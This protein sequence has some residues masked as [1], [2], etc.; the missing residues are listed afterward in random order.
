[1]I[2]SKQYQTLAS[3]TWP[4]FERKYKRAR[5][6]QQLKKYGFWLAALMLVAALYMSIKGVFQKQLKSKSPVIENL[7]PKKEIETKPMKVAVFKSLDR[8]IENCVTE[9]DI[10]NEFLAENSFLALLPKK[11]LGLLQNQR[12]VQLAGKQADL[13]S[14]FAALHLTPVSWSLQDNGHSLS[15]LIDSKT[16]MIMNLMYGSEE[17]AAYPTD[18]TTECWYRPAFF[19][20]DQFIHVS[21]YEVTDWIQDPLSVQIKVNGPEVPWRI[22]HRYTSSSTFNVARSSNQAF[23]P[24]FGGNAVTIYHSN[25]LT[26]IL[27]NQNNKY[28]KSIFYADRLPQAFNPLLF[29]SADTLMVLSAQGQRL[30]KLSMYGSVFGSSEITYRNNGLKSLKRLEPLLDPERNEL[31]M[32]APTNF[33]FVFFKVNIDTGEA[34]Q[35]YQTK[36]V[37]YGAEFSIVNGELSYLYKG[38][39]ITVKIP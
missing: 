8:P 12:H 5:K 22:D 4:L 10:S 32:V 3:A 13:T 37:W 9:Q 31:Y 6:L 23:T 36:S 1:M 39:S 16:L 24:N 28:R 15:A 29:H 33:H 21:F 14:A 26:P 27:F 18:F 11:Q 25:R 7:I 30:T 2:D 20:E 35:V 34:K 17:M 19:P 38:A